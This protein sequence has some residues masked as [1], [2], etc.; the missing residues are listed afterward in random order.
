MKKY[1]LPLWAIYCCVSFI[2][3]R[4]D[5][6]HWE[7]VLQIPVDPSA[8]LN[9]AIF[10]PNGIGIVAGG[11]RFE[12]ARLLVSTDKGLS[13]QAKSMSPDTRGFFG[14]CV[15]PDNKVYC[16]G[17]GL[18]L[19]KSTDAM[20]TYTLG[21]VP[22]PYEFMPALAVPSSDWGIGVV[23]VTTDSGA[24]VRFQTQDCNLISYQKFNFALHDIEMFDSL[25]GIAVGSGAV[26][27][28]VDAGLT[29]TR[30][31][32]VGDNFT[33]ISAVDSQHI[34]ICGLAGFIIKS[35]DAGATWQRLRNGTNLTLPQYKFWD[36]LCLNQQQI[37]AVGEQGCVVYSDDGGV[38]WMEY[39]RFTRNNLRFIKLC[40]DGKLLLG[41]ENGSL[42]RLQAK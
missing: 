40:P 14:A 3:C 9:T 18:T 16:C 29:W 28:T 15:S 31:P 20:I 5:L 30:L 26:L 7:S 21:R 11:A 24:I 4:K 36:I 13:W 2:S 39:D 42:F 6:L 10:L 35:D 41:G 19:C 1:L 38:H 25:R 8:Q 37:Y 32:V 34:F 12:T 17:L 33:S 23:N 27:K 22:G